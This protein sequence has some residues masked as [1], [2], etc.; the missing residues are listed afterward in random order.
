MSKFFRLFL[1]SLMVVSIYSINW[2]EK[3]YAYQPIDQVNSNDIDGYWKIKTH[4]WLGQTFKPTKNR[5]DAIGIRASGDGIVNQVSLYLFDAAGPALLS[6]FVIDLPATEGWIYYDFPTDIEITHVNQ[7]HILYVNS[8]SNDSYWAVATADTY[9]DGN[10]IVDSMASVGQDFAFVT[11]G[12]DAEAPSE[13]TGTAITDTSGTT[14]EQ[15]ATNTSGTPAATPAA[16]AD[17]SIKSPANATAIDVPEDNGE[18]IKITWSASATSDISGYK[19]YR[20]TSKNTGFVAVG[21]VEKTILEYIDSTTELGKT[22]Y[23][24]V[25][26]HKDKIESSNSNTVE[27]KSIDN[28]A[29]SAPQKFYLGSRGAKIQNF[30]WSKNLETDIAGYVFKVY[31][32]SVDVKSTEVKE[33]KLFDLAK[34]RDSYALDFSTDTLLSIDGSYDYYLAA[35]D[36]SGNISEFVKATEKPAEVKTETTNTQTETSNINTENIIYGL[37][38]L[39]IIA[40]SIFMIIKRKRVK[41]VNTMEQNK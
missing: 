32:T 1:V 39:L 20:S 38:L 26:A 29:P 36:N 22:Y 27:A 13:D 10:A 5:L 15:T 2:T 3:A 21:T 31:K 30:T 33:I 23:Y 4:Q 28:K 34:D 6:Q 14:T 12:Y 24:Y 16:T 17:T 19:I 8:P 9:T 25:R 18:A 40:L 41:A 37:G 11:Y 35:K 7:N